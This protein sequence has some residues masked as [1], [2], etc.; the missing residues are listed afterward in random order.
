M[1]SLALIGVVSFGFTDWLDGYLAKK[2]NQRSIIGAF[3]DPLADKVMI[4]SLTLGL[5]W[6]GLIPFELGALILSRDLFLS[7]C[8]ILLRYLDKPPGTG[9]WD[10]STATFRFKSVYLIPE[11]SRYPNQLPSVVVAVNHHKGSNN[12]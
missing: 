12:S 3:L 8:A 7:T 10:V 11:P 4:G 5:T 9:F 2:L 1:K 6:K